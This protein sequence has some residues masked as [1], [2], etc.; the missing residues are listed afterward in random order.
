MHVHNR[1]TEMIV[2]VAGKSLYTSFV[3]ANGLTSPILTQLGL[4]Q[5]TIRPQG[6]THYEFND[7]C[8]PAIFVSGL[9]NEDPGV[10]RT[11][12]LFFAEQPDLVTADLG[13]PSFLQNLN[14]TE[15]ATT[16]PSAFALGAQE[17]LNRCGIL[18]N[19]TQH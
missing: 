1:A 15:F 12:E 8:E 6:S 3:Q 11:A 14:I 13:Y 18:Y 10:A 16:I 2:L 4:Y 5:G 19:A 9:S 17:C 7:N